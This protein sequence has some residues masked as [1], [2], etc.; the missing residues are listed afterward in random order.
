MRANLENLEKIRKVIT[1]RSQ[2]K[3]THW[4]FLKE[5]S[6][7]AYK[8]RKN[9]ESKFYKKEKKRLFNSLYPRVVSDN[10]KFWKTVKNLFFQMKETMVIK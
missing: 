9:Y 3:K 10:Q 5:K 2:L 8:K 4:K 1:K 7:K 6:L